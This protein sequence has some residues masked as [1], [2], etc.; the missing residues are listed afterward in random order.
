M[1]VLAMQFSRGIW[2]RNETL[3]RRSTPTEKQR[4]ERCSPV[5]RGD[6]QVRAL[7][8][9]GIENDGL[10]HPRTTRPRSTSHPR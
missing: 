2:A 10:E 6:P 8:Q 1:L 3:A 4:A 7:P 5:P 9:N